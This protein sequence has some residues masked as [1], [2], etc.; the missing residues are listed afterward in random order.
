MQKDEPAR[1]PIWDSDEEERAYARRTKAYATSLSSL[2]LVTSTTKRH[3]PSSMYLGRSMG[4]GNPW[5]ACSGVAGRVLT[6]YGC[7]LVP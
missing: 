1:E 6:G 7:G 3:M 4:L 5:V 2:A